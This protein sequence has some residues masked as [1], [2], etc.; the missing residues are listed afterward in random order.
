MRLLFFIFLISVISSCNPNPENG[1]VAAI[2]VERDLDTNAF[3]LKAEEALPY[4]KTKNMSA[5]RCILI[6]M[7]RH[8]GLARWVEWDYKSDQ[9]ASATQVTHGCG[10]KAWGKDKSSDAPVFSNIPDSHLSSLGRY[11][12]GER[13]PSQWGIGVKYVL[14]GLDSTN[15]NAAKR[16]VVLHSWEKVSASQTF[17]NGAPESWGCPAVANDYMRYIDQVLKAEQ[18]P[19]LLWIYY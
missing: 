4:I 18:K 7:R 17:P 11:K 8:S 12:I 3:R 1:A 2:S 5:N 19:V 16:F 9:I 14:H 6:D 13:G 10:T 15:N